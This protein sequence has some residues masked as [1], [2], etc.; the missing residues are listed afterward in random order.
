MN[1]P[2]KI[3]EEEEPRQLL[4]RGSEHPRDL[5]EAQ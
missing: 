4:G 1:L 2:V 3:L 5:M